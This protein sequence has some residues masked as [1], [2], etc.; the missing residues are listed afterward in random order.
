MQRARRPIP[1]PDTLWLS[2]PPF[3]LLA[4][5]TGVDAGAAPPTVEYDLLDADGS[6]LCE[7]VR[8]ELDASWWA[9]FQPLVRR[10][11]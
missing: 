3:V 10:F 1:S 4:R 9:N 2:R 8:E 5:V 6:V 7:H 11:G